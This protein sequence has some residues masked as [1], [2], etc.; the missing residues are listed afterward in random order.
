MTPVLGVDWGHK[1]IGLAVSDS[2]RTLARPL[3][4]LDTQGYRHSV[5]LVVEHARQVEAEVIVVGLPLLS[6]GEE[7]ES[8]RRARKLGDSL[9]SKGFTV[10]YHNERFSS[11]DAPGRPGAEALGVDAAAAALVL[12]AYLDEAAA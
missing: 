10:V 9:A 5:S 3:A 11:Q 2:S 4:T 1:R 12:Q 7:G 6:E 8:A